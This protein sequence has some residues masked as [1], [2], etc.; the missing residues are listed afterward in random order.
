MSIEDSIVFNFR[1][2][3][4]PPEEGDWC[5]ECSSG[6]LEFHRDGDCSCH[7][8][9]PCPACTDVKLMCSECGEYARTE[10]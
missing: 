5:V 4:K 7:I 3:T 2:F 10:P 8:I 1:K 9:P 6:R